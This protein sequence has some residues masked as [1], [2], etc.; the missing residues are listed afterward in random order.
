[1]KKKTIVLAEEENLAVDLTIHDVSASL[2]TE[3]VEKIARPYYKGNL[4]AAIQDLIMK[5]LSE[6]DYVHSHI[7]HIRDSP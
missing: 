1:M 7:T 2:L 3:F 4:N 5:T 6:Q